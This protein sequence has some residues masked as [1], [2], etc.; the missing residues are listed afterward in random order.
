MGSTQAKMVADD[1]G[2]TT[3]FVDIFSLPISMAD[4]ITIGWTN[5][6]S[7]TEQDMEFRFKVNGQV[8]YSSESGL[9]QGD[10]TPMTVAVPVADSTGACFRLDT[11]AIDNLTVQVRATDE[12]KTIDEFWVVLE[13]SS[14]RTLGQSAIEGTEL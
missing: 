5:A 7:A 3:S 10:M 4:F 8:I 1:I 13:N 2:L 11:W 6:T 9:P 12:A 14:S